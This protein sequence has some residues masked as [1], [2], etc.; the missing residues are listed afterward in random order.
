VTSM[1]ALSMR[2]PNRLAK[3]S[4]DSCLVGSS[5][6]SIDLTSVEFVEP[7]GLVALA[8]L[9]S[10]NEARSTLT[11]IVPPVSADVARY[12]SRMGLASVLTPAQ[13]G[14][15]RLPTV[16]AVHHPDQLVELTRFD[17]ER[18]ARHVGNKLFE[19]LDG[20]IHPVALEALDIGLGEIQDNVRYHSRANQEDAYGFVAAQRYGSGQVNDRIEVAIG[21][22]GVGLVA[23]LQKHAPR[24]DHHAIDLAFTMM[25]SGLE[26]P[27]RGQGLATALEQVQNLRGS[28]VVRTGR[29][30]RF[31]NQPG[32][33]GASRQVSHIDG[34][35]I[36]FSV[37]C[38]PG[39]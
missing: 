10:H 5:A 13:I 27:A 39:T 14:Q 36:S 1:P 16:Q 4:F 3:P 21:D 25:V 9:L 22:A 30:M 31:S 11:D 8:C 6:P 32:T 12:L 19:L 26:D 7:Y 2:L 29:S 37:P 35:I 38:N 33:F 24:D 20:K 17:T 18:S 34:T 23:G 28:L 15:I